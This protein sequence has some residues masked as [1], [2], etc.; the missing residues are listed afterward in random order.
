MVVSAELKNDIDSQVAPQNKVL[1][2]IRG[3]KKGDFDLG[4][5]EMRFDLF[6]L[7]CNIFVDRVDFRWE[8]IRHPQKAIP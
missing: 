5:N 8:A 4:E 7:F 2:G 6:S 1:R 3:M